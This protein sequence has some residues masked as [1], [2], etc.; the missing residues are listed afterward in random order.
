MHASP[1]PGAELA[2]FGQ[3]YTAAT[4]CAFAAG[5]L[6]ARALSKT[7]VIYSGEHYHANREQVCSPLFGSESG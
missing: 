1:A 5:N 6:H 7:K 3:D 2:L 4:D